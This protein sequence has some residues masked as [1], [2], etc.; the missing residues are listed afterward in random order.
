MKSAAIL[1]LQRLLGMVRMA[2]ESRLAR[3]MAEIAACRARATELRL[4]IGRPGTGATTP[5][6]Q[7]AAAEMIAASRWT[8]RLAERADTE[9]ARAVVLEAASVAMREC[10]AGAVGRESAAAAMLEKA[11]GAERR[12]T[13][14]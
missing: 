8:Q 7:L 14:R 1:K 6:E 2:E 12:L 10:L 5:G 3:A 11:R 9:D 13:A 4:E